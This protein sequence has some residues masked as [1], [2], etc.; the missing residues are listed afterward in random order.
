MA[1]PTT[2]I[3]APNNVA[4][5]RANG[6]PAKVEGPFMRAIAQIKPVQPANGTP[7]AVTI[8]QM[9]FTSRNGQAA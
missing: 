7:S 8:A 4:A 3:L 9:N 6:N 5:V 2:S 1:G